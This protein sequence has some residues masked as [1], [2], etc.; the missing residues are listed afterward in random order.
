MNKN[1]FVKEVDEILNNSKDLGEQDFQKLLMFAADEKDSNIG[2]V[3]CDEL[4]EKIFKTPYSLEPMIPWNFFNTEIGKTIVK[5]KY[6]Q[7]SGIF[8]VK[9]I[10]ELTGKTRQYINQE[11]NVG[12]LRAYK[13]C[14]ISIV[15]KDDL[16]IYLAKKDISK[17]ILYQETEEKIVIP[18]NEN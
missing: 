2:A 13:K 17:D 18:K 14:G 16:E 7:N 5:I 10:A 9:E 8:F 11:I 12:N 15:Y 4:I 6:S 1:K 3:F